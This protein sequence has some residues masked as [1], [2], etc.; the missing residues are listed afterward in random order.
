MNLSLP[1][2]PWVVHGA[3]SKRKRVFT[4]IRLRKKS[5]DNKLREWTNRRPFALQLFCW[6]SEWGA[7]DQA[8]IQRPVPAGKNKAL[9]VS[10]LQFLDRVH[11]QIN[12]R[13]F[14][15]WDWNIT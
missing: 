11:V 10:L 13:P 3:W 8:L 5:S 14:V 9:K 1:P 2:V 7:A 15:N 6:V 12:I 4:V